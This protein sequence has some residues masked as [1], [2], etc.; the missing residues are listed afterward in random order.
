MATER[1]IQY[2]DGRLGLVLRDRDAPPLEAE[3]RDTW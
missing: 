3:R 2:L 1:S